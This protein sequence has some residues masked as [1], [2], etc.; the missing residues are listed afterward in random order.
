MAYRILYLSYDGMTDAL[1]QSQVL[2][3]LCHMAATGE[4]SFDI[5]SFEKPERFAAEKAK[6][7]A[8]IA[9]TS[10]R[11]F[12]LPYHKTPPVLST[13]KDLRAGWRQVKALWK[14][15]PY[16]IIHARGYI[17]ALLAHRAQRKWG[18]RFIFDMRGWWA[19]EK[20]EAGAWASS[21]YAPV[22]RYFKQKEAAF[23]READLAVSLTY[24]G[25]REIVKQGWRAADRIMVVPTCVDFNAFPGPSA[26]VRRQ[27]R[28]RL[29]ILPDA[30]V[31]LY[32][33]SLGGNYP[34]EEIFRIFL[35][36]RQLRPD[37]V[38]LLLTKTDPA[39]IAAQAGQWGIAAD[40]LR[41]ASCAYSEV[42]AYQNA[43]DCGLI[44]Y[45]PSYSGIGRSPTKLGEYW[46]SGLPVLAT[47][48]IGDVDDILAGHP[49]SGVALPF[50]LP[51]ED[52]CPYIEQLLALGTSPEVLRQYAQAYYSLDGGCRRYL[53]EY[54]KLLALPPVKA[55]P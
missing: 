23:F 47:A 27:V 33:G 35:Q 20:K 31:M 1:G 39:G 38:L 11:W 37:A 43:S 46:A 42:H 5:V 49:G 28:T 29:G 50:N 32:S 10:V 6:V 41:I 9:G 19:D 21:L 15:Q 40:S 24:A 14:Q 55:N 22:Y 17:T 8:R 44:V 45:T 7:E 54:H 25:Q 3:Y 13:L 16:D 48:G 18:A 52:L 26:E 53:A 12:P 4:V 51:P 36:L 34:V 30:Y 2:A